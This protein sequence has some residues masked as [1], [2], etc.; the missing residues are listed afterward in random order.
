MFNLQKSHI[1][2][3]EPGFPKSST[4]SPPHQVKWKHDLVP[5]C[6]FTVLTKSNFGI[7]TTQE[8]LPEHRLHANT[9][10]GAFLCVPLGGNE[11]ERE[12]LPTFAEDAMSEASKG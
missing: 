9:A 1:V 7:C 11:M 4:E 3:E 10:G 2:L 6:T 5:P 12:D 8:A